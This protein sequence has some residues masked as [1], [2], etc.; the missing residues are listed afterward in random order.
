MIWI[1]FVIVKLIEYL[2]QLGVGLISFELQANFSLQLG[3]WLAIAVVLFVFEVIFR[4]FFSTLGAGLPRILPSSAAHQPSQRSTGLE[5]RFMWPALP[6]AS[7]NLV[8]W[9]T[10]LPLFHLAWKFF[11]DMR[12]QYLGV[13]VVWMALLAV[14]SLTELKTR[15]ALLAYSRGNT[16]SQTPAPIRFL[17]ALLF[18]TASWINE[19]W[20]ANKKDLGQRNVATLLV[21]DKLLALA[22]RLTMFCI[23]LLATR[24]IPTLDFELNEDAILLVIFALI[25]V[26]FFLSSPLLTLLALL[27]LF[28][29]HQWSACLLNKDEAILAKYLLLI[30][31]AWSLHHLE[32]AV[33][34]RRAL[35]AEQQKH[36]QDQPIVAPW[37]T[38]S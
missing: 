4:S 1:A 33:R 35:H 9:V 6:L 29:R 20:F 36:K 24:L 37:G 8:F 16:A 26:G 19:K 10:I 13:L 3:L 27:G 34:Y 7:R 11:G 17:L 31:L 32:Q 25:A 2:P 21:D 18:S 5:T 12:Y 14:A 28:T 15:Q 22:P 38:A 23:G 30:I